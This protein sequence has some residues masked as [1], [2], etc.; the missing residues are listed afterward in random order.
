MVYKKKTRRGRPPKSVVTPPTTLIKKKSRKNFLTQ[1]KVLALVDYIRSKKN[2]FEGIGYTA[3]ATKLQEGTGI[4]VSSWNVKNVEKLAQVSV[5]KP[6]EAR[7]VYS[8]GHMT[9][10]GMYIMISVD[11]TQP[12]SIRQVIKKLSSLIKDK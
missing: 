11:V 6:R 8:N 9:N 1:K 3:A 2:E 7:N 12:E 5:A 10:G 4:T